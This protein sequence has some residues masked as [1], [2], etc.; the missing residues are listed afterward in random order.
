MGK[1]MKYTKQNPLR[2]VTLC[3]GYDSQCLA[4]KRLKEVY[5]K[6]DY[7]LVAWSEFDP[8][9]KTPLNKQPAVV[10]HNALFKQLAERNQSTIYYVLIYGCA[11]C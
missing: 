10:A 6:F 3:S 5:P 4:L 11:N 2:V 7:E 9:I 1:E 8:E